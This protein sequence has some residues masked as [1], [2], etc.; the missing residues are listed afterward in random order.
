MPSGLVLREGKPLPTPPSGRENGQ[1]HRRL[2]LE[3]DLMNPGIK[4]IPLPNANA[5]RRRRMSG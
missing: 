4:I 1:R 5:L 3:G 2:T